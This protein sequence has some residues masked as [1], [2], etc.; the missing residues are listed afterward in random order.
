MNPNISYKKSFKSVQPINCMNL[1][2]FK[3]RGIS[4]RRSDPRHQR[5]LA[6]SRLGSRKMTPLF[7]TKLSEDLMKVY[8]QKKFTNLQIKCISISIGI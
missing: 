5:I 3:T 8:V 4:F 7:K 6:L 2:K 1:C